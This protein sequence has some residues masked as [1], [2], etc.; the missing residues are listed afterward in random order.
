MMSMQEKSREELVVTPELPS[1]FG[2]RND[3]GRHRFRVN[4]PV[5]PDG[6]AMVEIQ[7]R[8]GKF[9]AMARQS[10]LDILEHAMPARVYEIDEWAELLSS[11]HHGLKTPI[12]EPVYWEFL[13]VLPPV[14]MRKRITLV[15]GIEVVADFLFAE[16]AE[17][18]SA[19]FK[20]P[21]DGRLYVQHT[22][23]FNRG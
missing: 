17:R 13:E 22:N 12:S 19:F 6:T 21:V 11:W 23:I 10:A 4:S 16:G 1:L 20:D 3:E 15:S 14:A 18:V 8:S 7:E 5:G 9:R 2:L